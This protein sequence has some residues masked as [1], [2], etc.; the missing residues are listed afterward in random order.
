M[1]DCI[2][3]KIIR[4]ESP[5]HTLWEDDDFLVFLSDKPVNPGHILL[6]PKEHIDYVF[7]LKEPLFSKIFQVAQILSEPLRNAFEAPRIGVVIEGFSVRHLHIHLVPVYNVAELDPNRGKKAT[8]DELTSIAEKI[9]TAF[10][11]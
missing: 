4:N 3:C 11:L 1:Q 6:I 8:Y 7:N 9:R 2:F 10:S 5:A